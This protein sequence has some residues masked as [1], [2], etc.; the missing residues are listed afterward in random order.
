MSDY[1]IVCEF[2]PFHN[3]HAYL[4]KKARES[5]AD[6]IICVMSGNAVQRGELAMTDKYRRAR[7]AL[8]C[9]ADLVLE[10]PY[11]WSS[12]GAEFF[13]NA[14]TYIASFF[15][16]TLFFGSEQGKGEALIDAARVC[17]SAEFLNRF[18]ERTASGEGAAAVF[19]SL[20]EESG[21]G[22]LG[23]NDLLG[24]SYIRSVLRNGYQMDIKTTERI[25]TAYNSE[26]LTGELP[27]ASAIRR[28]VENGDLES[29]VSSLPEASARALRD[30]VESG[31]LVSNSEMLD[32]ALMYFRLH[33]GSDFEGVA[34][35]SG[36]LANRICS[37]A[38]EAKD[39][40][41]LMRL[42]GTKVYTNARIR[43]AMLYCMTG[44][45]EE[46]LRARPEYT[47]LL[48][49]NERGRELLALNRKRGGIKVVTK[50][51]D[52]P[53]HSEQYELS[54][55]LDAIFTL[56]LKNKKSAGEMM[57]KSAYI[58]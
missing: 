22:S 2:N 4:F 17:E 54:S 10:L 46:M 56:S 16:D 36:G 23:S 9:G 27:S 6:R 19:A 29:A 58:G 20:L 55:K 38:R 32:A 21:F 18:K 37:A 39:G 30:A 1:G 52:A 25:G 15:C 44:V 48:A 28:L 26:T 40:E 45:S 14:A 35:T 47:T 8:E 13:A 31:E 51:A 24:I 42:S 49:A 57:K 43:R 50:P 53:L 33:S 11:P 41:E 3:G 34:E 7:T 12:A 5:G